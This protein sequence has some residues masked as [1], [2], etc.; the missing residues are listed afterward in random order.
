MSTLEYRI[1]PWK[2]LITTGGSSPYDSL[3]IHLNEQGAD[4]W[5]FDQRIM[6]EYGTQQIEYGV[7]VKQIERETDFSDWCLLIRKSYGVP[8]IISDS[9]AQRL[10]EIELARAAVGDDGSPEN[11]GP[12]PA[13]FLEAFIDAGKKGRLD[14]CFASIPGFN[15]DALMYGLADGIRDLRDQGLRAMFNDLVDHVAAYI[16]E[17]KGGADRDT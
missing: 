15:R 11:T 2:G 9:G 4:G 5:R 16:N 14:G 1:L 3:E 12:F 8:E 17:R 10:I 6:L 7:F 13:Q